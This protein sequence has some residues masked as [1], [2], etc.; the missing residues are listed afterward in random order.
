MI[1]ALNL[2]VEELVKDDLSKLE[3][4]SLKAEIAKNS[5]LVES[6]RC[7]SAFEHVFIETD[8][9]RGPNIFV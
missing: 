9:G 7:D 8:S 4:Q 5:S 3:M 2:I 1:D 6:L